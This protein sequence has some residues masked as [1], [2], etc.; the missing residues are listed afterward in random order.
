MLIL[1]KIR[2]SDPIL[3][4]VTHIPCSCLT[5][6]S[7]T[8]NHCTKQFLGFCIFRLRIVITIREP[9][10]DK[11]IRSILFKATVWN[12]RIIKYKNAQQAR[13]IHSFNRRTI[14]CLRICTC[15]IVSPW[16]WLQYV[17]EVCRSVQIA[18]YS[19]WKLNLYVYLTL[20][21]ERSILL[22]WLPTCWT[23]RGSYPNM[24]KRFSLLQSRFCFQHSFLFKWHGSSAPVVKQPLTLFRCGG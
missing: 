14:R 3:L 22:L 17:A 13:T 6:R 24:G 15:N 20:K 5:H 19:S 9:R 1:D 18:L 8:S 23:V 10:Y 11:G 16:W 21:V 2:H 7:V 4:N 12:V